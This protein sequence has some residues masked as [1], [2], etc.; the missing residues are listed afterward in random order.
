MKDNRKEFV[1]VI[2]KSEGMDQD[3]MIK[4]INSI[5]DTQKNIKDE[6]TYSLVFFNEAYK[7]SAMGKRFN[8]IR[9]YNAKTYIPKGKS[10]LYDAM[11]F[12]IT[13]VGDML[14]DTREEDRPCQV[15]VIVIGES[16]NA[17]TECEY[18]V[19]DEMIKT[20]KYVYKWDFVFYGD[21]NTS[22]D[23]QKGGNLANPERMF[24]EINSY[25]TSMR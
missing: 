16:D 21:G 5:I 13:S 24:N 9:K 18:T 2:G 23:I 19:L 6:S 22:F 14:A 1:F 7:A 8:Q 15:C 3:A 17:S 25:I 11:G 12:A 4:G 20:Q 10:A